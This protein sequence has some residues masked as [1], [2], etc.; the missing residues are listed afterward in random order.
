MNKFSAGFFDQK[1]SKIGDKVFFN[2]SKARDP[3]VTSTLG[4]NFDPQ[5]RSCPLGTGVKLSLVDEILC[6]PLR[7]FKQ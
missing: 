7:S 6:P 2:W 5:G 4:A 3:F 1:F